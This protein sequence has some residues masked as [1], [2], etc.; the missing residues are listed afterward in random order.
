MS[1]S[2]DGLDKYETVNED[3]QEHTYADVENIS[4]KSRCDNSEFFSQQQEARTQNEHND[5]Y[6]IPT[7]GSIMVHSEGNLQ[8][9]GDNS[10]ENDERKDHVYAVVHIQPGQGKAKFCKE[11]VVQGECLD[12]TRS[13]QLYANGE[14]PM[15]FENPASSGAKKEVANSG[16]AESKD[17][18]YAVVDN[19]KK[20]RKP[21]QV[22]DVCH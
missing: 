7:E 8:R 11:L 9:N 4:G 18:L 10:M 6:L 21:P 13:S 17:Y 16:D 12:A 1:P 3:K 15:Q 14:H 20:K 2:E 5:G 19:A 22:M